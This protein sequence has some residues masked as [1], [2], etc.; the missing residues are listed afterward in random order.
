MKEI[1]QQ[2]WSKR[3][4]TLLIIKRQF[5]I[6]E[7]Q[8]WDT[9]E[10]LTRGFVTRV[11]LEFQSFTQLDPLSNFYNVVDKTPRLW[12]PVTIGFETKKLSTDF[13]V[14]TRKFN[15]RLAVL[16]VYRTLLDQTENNDHYYRLFR[17]AYFLTES[18]LVLAD[19]P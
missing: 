7:M 4:L 11:G 3:S 8:S 18:T 19:Q 14:V 1:F 10:R 2:A 17:F 6:Y 9:V 12:W 16:F 13:A 15:V 5:H